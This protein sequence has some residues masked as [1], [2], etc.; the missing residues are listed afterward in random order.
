[1]KGKSEAAVRL[2]SSSSGVVTSRASRFCRSACV[3]SQ[4][5]VGARRAIQVASWG[6]RSSH[7]TDVV[8]DGVGVPLA[9]GLAHV[10]KH[11]LVGVDLAHWHADAV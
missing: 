11:V 5:P 10:P 7:L 9:C 4:G 1:M 6:Q 2:P 3:S 8:V